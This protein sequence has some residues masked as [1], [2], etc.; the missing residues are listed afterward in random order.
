MSSSNPGPSVTS[1]PNNSF[2]VVSG[3]IV[4]QSSPSSIG[5]LLTNPNMQ[6]TGSVNNYCQ[7]SN[8]NLLNGI[9]SSSDHIVYP[10]NIQNDGTG[11]MDMGVCSSLYA[12]A[13]YSITG[14]NDGYVFMSSPIGN[15]TASG[16]MVLGTD[17]NGTSNGYRFYVNGYSKAIAQWSVKITGTGLLQAGYGL[18]LSNSAKVIINNG[19]TT[20]YTVPAGASYVNLTTSAASLAMTFP[21]GSSAIDGLILIVTPSATVAAVTWSSTGATF[22]G[23]PSSF[24]ANTPVRMIY[25]QPTTKWYQI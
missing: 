11:F 18:A 7:V 10:D 6:A 5:T 14:P 17:S 24:V 16:D 9:N 1:T 2:G 4:Q 25:D 23:A 13:Q 8:Q 19:A 12:Q 3:T 20:S 22:I 21:A 15:A